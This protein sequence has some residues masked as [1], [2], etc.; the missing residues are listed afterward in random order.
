MDVVD[1]LR[2][3]ERARMHYWDR[4]DYFIPHRLKWRAHMARHLFHLLPGESILDLGCGDGRWT[5][6]IAE[7]HDHKHPV[8]AATFNPDYFDELNANKPENVEPVLLNEFP[9]SLAGRKFDTVVAWHMLPNPNYGAFLHEARKLL[10]PGG[11]FLLFEPNPWNPY[12]QLRRL[13]TRLIPFVK[14]REE[15]PRFNRIE[16]MSILS[17]IGFTGIRILP[18]DF[19]FPPLPKALLWPVQNLSLIL[20]NMPYVRNFAGEL[21]LNG[22]NPA[23]EDW[24]RPYV[25]LTEHAS[26]K[27]RVSVV[28]PCH[29]EEANLKPLVANLTGYFDDYIQ[30]IVLVD[31]NSTDR[32]AEVGETLHEQDPRVR[33]VRR[34]PPNGVGRA[35]RDGL[36]AAQGD[37]VLLMDCDFQHILPEL[38]GL[39][40]AV[41]GGADVAIGSRF[42]RDS[43]L[44][45]YAFTKILANR[46]FHLLAR[47]LFRKYLRDLTNNLKLMKREVAQ[48]LQL[49]AHDFAANAETGLQP[50]LLGYKVE[51]VPISWI[52]RSVDMGFSS[53]NLHRTGPNYLKVFLRLFWRQWRGKSITLPVEPSPQHPAT[54]K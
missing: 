5:R 28:V 38:T 39:F 26:L 32:T 50:L 35:L 16:M 48:N 44:L 14:L 46:A 51:E 43:V 24:K 1:A 8:T 4:K 11:R 34:T 6:E 33:L 47:I 20:E 22:Q 13:V 12:S 19:L 31:D 17:E 54:H 53:F 2:E 40:D 9:G 37:Y 49:E 52:N 45:N 41:A 30:E 42:S 18:Y 36:A 3:R 25:P 7:L 21:Y 15:G 10:K 29:N 23:P 27:G